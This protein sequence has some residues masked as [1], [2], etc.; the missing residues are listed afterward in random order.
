MD[1]RDFKLEPEDFDKFK[2]TLENPPEPNDKLKALMRYKKPAPEP[3]TI[4]VVRFIEEYEPIL[5][6]MAFEKEDDAKSAAELMNSGAGD[7]CG[8]HVV[9]T[10]RLHHCV[11][12]DL[13]K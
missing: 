10:M 13:Q 7:D 3:S 1:K 4:Y 9:T 6:V 11:P 8:K 2:Q 5:T 12:S